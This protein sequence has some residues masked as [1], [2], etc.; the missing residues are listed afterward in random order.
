MSGNNK[1]STLP[2]TGEASRTRTWVCNTPNILG[3]FRNPAN[4]G[5]PQP[6]S[7]IPA[8]NGGTT[9]ISDLTYSIGTGKR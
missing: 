7:Y 9:R 4:T 2:I 3:P 5:G 6:N 1:G 8:I